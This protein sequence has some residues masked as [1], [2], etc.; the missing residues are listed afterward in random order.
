MVYN[1]TTA[2]R[3]CG[4]PE[5]YG[6]RLVSIKNVVLM[7]RSASVHSPGV[8]GLGYWSTDQA[9]FMPRPLFL[10]AIDILGAFAI[11]MMGV[12]SLL[13]LR[14]NDDTDFINFWMLL[15][16]CAICKRFGRWGYF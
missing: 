9:S 16:V 3:E 15:L 13:L 12:Y 6:P 11:V 8:L 7:M 5:F 10:V 2:I 14:V 4:D 1:I